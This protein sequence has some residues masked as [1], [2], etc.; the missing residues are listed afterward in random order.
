MED[1]FGCD[2][3]GT[4]FITLPFADD[5]CLI[6]RNKIHHQKIINEIVGHTE[7]MNMTLK[8]SKC[9][10]ISIASGSSK[11]VIFKIKNFEIPT[12]KEKPEKFLGSFITYHGKTSDAYKIIQEKYTAFLENVNTTSIRNEYKVRILNDYV[13]P[14]MRY[15][16][17]VHN[18]TDTQL[19]ELD[20]L[21][22][23]YI[24]LW[25]NLPPCSTNAML[26]GSEGLNLTQVSDLYFE[27][28]IMSY[29]SSVIKGDRRVVHTLQSK[30]DREGQWSCKMQ[31]RGLVASSK[32]VIEHQSDNWN[33]T[34]ND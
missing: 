7:S 11:E 6:T 10:S 3:N 25:L 13:M 24:R 9:R 34:K 22:T 16:L 21:Q 15:I 18:L 5:F 26:Y 19:E 20:A 33:N 31:K 8:P 17:S 12:V 2:L 14:S 23:R 1:T 27:C 4:K 30:L 28:R 29:P 32:I